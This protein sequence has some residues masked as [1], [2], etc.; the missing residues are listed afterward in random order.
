[1]KPADQVFVG[2][3]GPELDKGSSALLAAHQPGG[4]ILFKRNIEDE[5]QLD[6]LMRTLRRGLPPGG[7]GVGA[8]GGGGGALGGGGG[9][10]WRRRGAGWT[11]CA[12][13]WRRRRPPRR[14]PGA[15]PA[16]RSRRGTGSP[17]RCA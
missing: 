16:T 2:L 3:P 12:R 17:S 6:R 15:R 8:G 1:M 9:C 7:G 13:W 14:S 11:G 4:V 10:V 5:D